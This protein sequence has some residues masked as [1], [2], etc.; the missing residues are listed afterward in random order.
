MANLGKLVN[1][2][3]AGMGMGGAA[4]AGGPPPPAEMPPP[5][6]AAMPDQ[7]LDAKKEMLYKLPP[8]LLADVAATLAADVPMDEL[9]SIVSSFT[10]GM[11]QE[12]GTQAL[13]ESPPPMQGA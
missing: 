6:M 12:Q 9:E 2:K 7:E 11:D 1:G 10:G 13:P 5:E 4:A 3:P 8:E